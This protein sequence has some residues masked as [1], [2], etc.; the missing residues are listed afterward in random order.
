MDFSRISRLAFNAHLRRLKQS[1]GHR[2]G[3]VHGLENVCLHGRHIPA[4]VGTMRTTNNG[5]SSQYEAG[6]Q[7]VVSKQRSEASVTT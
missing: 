1:R 6:Q 4:R 2:A 5:H 3:L 7:S